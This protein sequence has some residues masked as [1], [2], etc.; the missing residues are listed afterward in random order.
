[1]NHR[2]LASVIG[3][4]ILV[5]VMALAALGGQAPPHAAKVAEGQP[6]LQGIWGFATITPLERPAEA[7][8]ASVNVPRPLGAPDATVESGPVPV[9]L[10]AT[11]TV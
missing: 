10:R 11:T 2:F 8:P 3:L 7:V 5:A 1:M 9:V 4:V 6:D